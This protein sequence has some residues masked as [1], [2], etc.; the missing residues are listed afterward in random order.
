MAG[1]IGDDALEIVGI[2]ISVRGGFG[3]CVGIRR[4]ICSGTGRRRLRI[5]GLFATSTVTERVDVGLGRSL[6][7]PPVRNAE[8][9]S[10]MHPLQ[11]GARFRRNDNVRAEV[12]SAIHRRLRGAHEKTKNI[13]NASVSDREID[14]RDFAGLAGMGSNFA[15][16]ENFGLQ[17]RGADA[18][19]SDIAVRAVDEGVEFTGEVNRVVGVGDEEIRNVD[20]TA[21]LDVLES[22]LKTVFGRKDPADAFEDAEVGVTESVFAGDGSLAGICGI[23]WAETTVRVDITGW[24]RNVNGDGVGHRIIATEVRNF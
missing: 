24:K 12:G 14:G 20:G 13:L 8:L 7:E 1:E 23:P 3:V 5:F 22:A 18:I 6:H 15:F 4:W 17:K 10:E 2:G 16:G 19:E 21:R 9:T 11:E